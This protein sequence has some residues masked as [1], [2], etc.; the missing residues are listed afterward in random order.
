MTRLVLQFIKSNAR[1]IE[2]GYKELILSPRASKNKQKFSNT[3]MLYRTNN[4]GPFERD[5]TVADCLSVLMTA[6]FVFQLQFHLRI[7]GTRSVETTIG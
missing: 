3:I 7:E 6:L 5:I 2:L 4:T 1:L